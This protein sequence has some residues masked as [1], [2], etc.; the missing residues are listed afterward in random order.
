MS[1]KI[2]NEIANYL[3]N[4]FDDIYLINNKMSLYYRQVLDEHKQAYYVFDS[5]KEAFNHFKNKYKHEEVNLL[6]E[7]DLPDNFLER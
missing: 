5:F 6:I 1:E 2:N 7:N 3:V 4:S